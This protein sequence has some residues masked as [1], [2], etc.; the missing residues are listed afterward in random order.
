MKDVLKVNWPSDLVFIDILVDHSFRGFL[1]LLQTDPILLL[2]AFYLISFSQ[3]IPTKFLGSFSEL[4]SQLV[5]P[6]DHDVAYVLLAFHMVADLILG[7][8]FSEEFLLFR[9]FLAFELLD[10]RADVHRLV[11]ILWLF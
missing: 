4:I 9:L 1:E 3:L 7:L 6:R 8:D 5:K 2:W 10:L 11:S